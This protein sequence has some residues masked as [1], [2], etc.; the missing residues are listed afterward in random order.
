MSQVMSLIIFN[1]MVNIIKILTL[2]FF[3]SQK[4][5]GPIGIKAGI[6]KMCVRIANSKEPDQ[7]AS[8]EAV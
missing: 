8:E 5:D 3:Y 2:F 7:A 1:I 4:N 6:H